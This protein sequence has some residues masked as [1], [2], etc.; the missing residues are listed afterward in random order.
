MTVDNPIRILVVDDHPVL[1][2]GIAS[3]LANEADMVLVGEANNGWEGIEIFR[4][5]RPDITLM[6]L[7]MPLMNGSEAILAI[8]KDFPD[9]RIIVLTT[10]RGDAQAARAIRAGAYGY[11]LKTMIRRELVETIRI[12]HSGRKK[13]PPEIA[14][15]LAEHHTDSVRDTD[16]NLPQHRYDLL[17]LVPLDGHDPLFL[18]VDSLSFHLVQKSPVTS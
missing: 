18:Q 2:E 3:L 14:L 5:H 16:F 8:R 6:D 12:V 17:W 13:V 9:A 7:Q 11:L 10:H 15:E 4:S 1:R